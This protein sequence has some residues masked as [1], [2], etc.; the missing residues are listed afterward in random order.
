MSYIINNSRG[1]L[2]VVV[3][4]GTVN[5]SVTDLSLV[6][7]GVTEYG[8][9]ENENYVYLLENFANSTAPLQP[10]LGQ[11]WYNSTTD[12]ISTYSTANTWSA[13]ASQTYVQA[14]KVSPV[15]TGTPTAPTATVNT[16]TT[17]IATTAFVLNQ[18]GSGASTSN[19]LTGGNISATGT[20]TGASLL[21][22]IVSATANVTGGNISTSGIVSAGGNVIGANFIGNVI[23]PAGGAVST[24]GNVTG[25]NISTSGIVSAGGNIIGSNIIGTNLLAAG[26]SLSSNVISAFNVTSNISGGNISTNGLISATGNITGGNI[27]ATRHTGTTVS[28]TGNITGGNISTSGIISATGNITTT[29]TIIADTV[30]ANTVITTGTTSA[31]RLPNLTQTQINALS[32]QNGDMVYNTTDNL[33]QVYQNGVW[34]DFTISYYS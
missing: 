19:V 28:V 8:T 33:P 31:F 14:Q 3:P 5:T 4:D 21:G 22:S 7:R 9:A 12:V 24:T 32:S 34:W 17:Q 6:G 20:V 30:I 29:N 18:L 11:L 2:L 26:L 13:L 27:S 10:I 1:Q 15:F 25:G 16:S 23:P